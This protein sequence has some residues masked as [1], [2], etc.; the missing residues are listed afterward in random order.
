MPNVNMKFLRTFLALVEEKS[1]AKTA[2]R[3][4]IAKANVLVHVAAIEKV[5]GER[6]LERRFPPN[7]AEMG[8]TQ[9]TEAG[10]AFLP[11]AVETVRAHDKM[12]ADVAVEQDS[13]EVDRAIAA[14]LMELAR[15]ALRHDL[16]DDDRKRIYDSLLG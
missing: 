3:M 12:F 13:Q 15:D 6:L 10:R 4:G 11:K 2:R 7:R 8:R 9:L 1:T 5:I 14:G 16:S